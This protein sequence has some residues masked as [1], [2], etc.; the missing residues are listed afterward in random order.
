MVGLSSSADN[1]QTKPNSTIW[2]TK[3]LQNATKQESTLSPS[4]PVQ[5]TSNLVY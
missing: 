1:N 2:I 4:I 3:S 5:D